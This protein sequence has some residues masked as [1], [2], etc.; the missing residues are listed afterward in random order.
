MSSIKSEIEGG[1]DESESENARG[2]DAVITNEIGQLSVTPSPQTDS[3]DISPSKENDGPKTSEPATFAATTTL[4]P[5]EEAARAAR[6]VEWPTT[7]ITEPGINDCLFGRGGGTNHHPGNKRYRKLVEENKARYL[8]SKRLD[9]PLV[10]IEIINE[11]RAL[12]PP[13]RFLKQDEETKLWNDVGEKKAREKTSQALREKTP[14]KQREGEAGEHYDSDDR[15]AR[16]QP[17]TSSPPASRFVRRSQLARDHSLGTEIMADNEISLEGFSWEEEDNDGQV[18]RSSSSN[19]THAIFSSNNDHPPRGEKFYYPQYYG[20]GRHDHYGDQK[21]QPPYSQHI[22]EHSLSTNPLPNTNVSRPAYPTFGDPPTRYVQNYPPNYGHI[23]PPPPPSH[24]HAQYPPPPPPPSSRNHQYQSFP[25]PQEQRIREHSL[26]MIP[27]NGTITLQPARDI[28]NEKGG[29]SLYDSVPPPLPPANAYHRGPPPPPP[30]PYYGYGSPPEQNWP[31][32]PGAH[33]AQPSPQFSYQVGSSRSASAFGRYNPMDRSNSMKSS[34]SGASNSN[35]SA[36]SR[37]DSGQSGT[38]TATSI[39]NPAA[40]GTSQDYSKIAELFRESS[41]S[42]STDM[43]GPSNLP[44]KSGDADSNLKQEENSK[45]TAESTVLKSCLIRKLSGGGTLPNGILRQQQT[46]DANVHRPEAV[47]RDTSN[48]TETVETKR[49]IK[50]VVLSRDQS[51]AARRLKEKQFA[52]C[53]SGESRVSSKLTK[54]EMLDR[55]LSVEMNMLGLNDRE[56]VRMSTEDVLA[57]F[58]EDSGLCSP[59]PMSETPSLDAYP[60]ETIGKCNRV[61]TIDAIA[62]EIA[63]GTPPDDWDDA[64]DL[65]VE[66]DEIADPSGV[67]PDIAEK[68]LNGDM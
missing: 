59:S 51:E 9:K 68:W 36:S 45:P 26:Q 65:I 18:I 67:S 35:Y 46:S 20:G 23:P 27:P 33:T 3:W 5:D 29:F 2:D 15:T 10:A 47:K 28:Y 43:K 62:L 42:S 16:F 52:N 66:E 38:S 64:L 48:Q 49:S 11:W 58:L 8:S 21:L 30:S 25:P 22:R 1:G 19:N 63:N 6:R 13:G 53:D 17:G 55:K 7:G 31:S 34:G 56:L 61:T 44:T 14:V 60:P 4:S 50:R 57:S 32:P 37:R 54:A 24:H 39:E 40:A 41:D 12:D